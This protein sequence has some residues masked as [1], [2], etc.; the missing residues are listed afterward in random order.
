MVK[1][2]VG[3]VIVVIVFA[4]ACVFSFLGIKE[5]EVQH[6]PELKV[7][8]FNIRMSNATSDTGAKSWAKRKEHLMPF[9]LKNDPDIIG[10]QEVTGTQIVHLEEG[11]GET[12]DNFTI[13]R[14]FGPDATQLQ[15]LLDEAAGIFYKKERFDLV[16]ASCFW[17]SETPEQISKG[18]DAALVRICVKVVLYDKY[19]DKTFAVYNTHFDHE[20]VN[21]RMESSKLII[22]KMMANQ[23]IP[24][25][26]M[27]DLNFSEGTDA[28]HVLLA[29]GVLFDTKHEAKSSDEGRTY[30]GF[31]PTATTGLPIDYI[32]TMADFDIHSYKVLRDLDT[33]G[34]VLS[35]HFPLLTVM[36]QL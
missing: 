32:F 6:D 36:T 3:S 12:Y 22:S 13:F 20:G 28:Y 27:G 1:R 4:A 16:S 21:A 30:N 26:L 25:I 24:S 35:D 31:N 2:I 5:P 11:L 15:T 17:L 7:M 29:G 34:N 23:D 14:N 33:D 9:V 18:W 10:F 19:T 8:S